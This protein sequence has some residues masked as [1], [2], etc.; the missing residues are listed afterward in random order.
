[1][2]LRVNRADGSAVV[3]GLSVLH[4]GDSLV[5]VV[6][7]VMGCAPASLLFG[8]YDA[9]GTAL[10]VGTPSWTFVPGSVD[11]VYAAVSLASSAAE[12]LAAA[13]SAGESVDVFLNLAEG[14][15][16]TWLDIALPFRN[17]PA[18]NDTQGGA[19]VAFVSKAALAAIAD[20]IIPM[21]TLT[22][23]QRE[24]RFALLLTRLAALA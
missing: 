5:I 19:S 2:T 22:A 23:A 24:A 12:T 11:R 13:L 10:H 4:L 16:R 9:D 18:V 8:I 21:P 17:S 7:N 1:M 14:G 15:G 3:E 6:T 20:E